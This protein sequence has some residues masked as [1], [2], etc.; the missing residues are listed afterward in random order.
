MEEIFSFPGLYFS[1]RT[2]VSLGNASSPCSSI[3]RLE[4]KESPVSKKFC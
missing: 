2:S 3:A 4:E 1:A